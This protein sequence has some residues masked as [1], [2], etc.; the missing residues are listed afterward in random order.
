MCE[1]QQVVSA[2]GNIRDPPGCRHAC[3]PHT[4][5]IEPADVSAYQGHSVRRVS[6]WG[7]VT[8]P[9]CVKRVVVS[10]LTVLVSSLQTSCDLFSSIKPQGLIV[11]LST[12]SF[13]LVYELNDEVPFTQGDIWSNIHAGTAIICACL[14]TYRPLFP[15]LAAFSNNVRQRYRNL[16]NSTR[17]TRSTKSSAEEIPV[18]LP[19]SRYTEIADGHRDCSH[20][21]KAVGG[22]ESQGYVVDMGYPAQL[23]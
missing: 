14:P 20:H 6:P 23:Y 11:S 13:G 18:D 9:L 8:S 22:T 19:K 3:A 21:T 17:R 12:Y 1:P 4:D 2:K 16:V 10:E 5:G 15:R 7:L